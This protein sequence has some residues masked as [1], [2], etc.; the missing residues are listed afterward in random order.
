MDKT[1]TFQDL[2]Q[3]SAP[4]DI[5]EHEQREAGRG[6]WLT[7]LTEYPLIKRLNMVDPTWEFRVK[8]SRVINNGEKP[9]VVEVFGELTIKGVTRASVGTDEAK[10]KNVWEN[11]QKVGEEVL[12][13]D[14]N[15]T[16]AAVTDCLKRCARLFGAGSYLLTVPRIKA[17]NVNE[18]QSLFARWYHQQFGGNEPPAKANPTNPR[19]QPEPP[20]ERTSDEPK[21]RD[22][23]KETPAAAQE[24]ANAPAKHWYKDGRTRKNFEVS[25][26]NIKKSLSLTPEQ[27]A[28]ILGFPENAKKEDMELIMQK[29]DNPGEALSFIREHAK[30]IA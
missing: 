7:Y 15:S 11:K 18:A 30:L 12:P 4:F 27:V 8:E 29:F 24:A 2:E 13:L 1:L 9:D 21:Q 10:I 23:A 14:E 17:S 20:A 22:S 19:R 16:K 26:G 28:R 3:I 25:L 6:E 5:A